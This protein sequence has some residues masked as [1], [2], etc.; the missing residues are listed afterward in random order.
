MQKEGAMSACVR[1]GW[2]CKQGVCPYAKWDKEKKKRKFL[3][4][5][6]EDNSCRKYEEINKEISKS[7]QPFIVYV[8][9]WV[10]QVEA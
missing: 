3:I 4:K 6:K 10:P 7:A 8:V 5:K 9:W 1:S 2:C